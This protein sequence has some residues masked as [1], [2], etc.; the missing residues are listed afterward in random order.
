M[1]SRPST[2]KVPDYPEDLTMDIQT[3]EQ[4]DQ[5]VGRTL[6]SGVAMNMPRDE[7]QFEVRIPIQMSAAVKEE[8]IKV[9][10]SCGIH[11]EIETRDDS[12]FFVS[13]DP[14]WES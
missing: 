10:S 6:A 7:Q 5:M 12:T 3:K 11:G 8:V 13:S 1:Y 9:L 14:F 4:H 2:P